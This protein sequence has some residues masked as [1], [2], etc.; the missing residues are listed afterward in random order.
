M[1]RFKLKT[2]PIKDLYII[3]LSPMADSRGYFERLFCKKELSSI[4]NKTIKQI[5][6]SFTRKKGSI[7]GMHYQLPP[8]AETKIIK[9]IK[10]SIFDVAID[11]RKDSPTFLKLHGEVISEDNSK[12]FFVPEGFA[13]GFQSLEKNIE[14]IYFTT[15]YYDCK[16]ERGVRYNDNM[17]NIKWPLKTSNI[18][19][20][21]KSYP[22]IDS[23]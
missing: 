12:L 15:Q 9:C 19:D 23:D 5:N 16:S 1:D 11:L 10:G 2:T 8:M 18:S 3:E 22:D 13:H 6:Y 21:D 14:V 4:L 17:I 20:K 7:R